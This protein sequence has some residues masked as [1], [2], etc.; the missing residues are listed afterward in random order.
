MQRC[1]IQGIV[2]GSAVSVIT[3]LCEG[4]TETLLQPQHIWTIGRD[5]TC[6]IHLCDQRVSRRHAAIQYIKNA[7]YSGFYLV[8][9]SSTN[10]TFVNG[11]PVYCPIKL[12]D[13][14]HLRLGSMAFSFTRILH[15]P[16]SCL[17][18]LSSYGCNLLH[19]KAVMKHQ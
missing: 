5:R 12:Q 7:E 17:E 16:K 13:G 1:Y 9:F 2:D 19:T 8:D 10:G 4:K 15:H 18:L 11:E 3:N 14:D 6:G